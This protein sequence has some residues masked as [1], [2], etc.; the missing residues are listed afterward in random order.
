MS[1][2]R[3]DLQREIALEQ[4]HVDRVY[5]NLAASTASARTL[6]RSGAEIYKTD[7]DD[8]LR[9]ES[10][11]ALFERD[12]FAYQAAKRLAIL[13][14]EHEGLVFGRL[15]LN[16]PETRYIGRLGVRDAEY[17][18]LVIDWRA[19]AAEPFYRATQ[20]TPMNVIRRRVLRCR[21]DNVIGLEDDLLDT[22]VETD[23]PILGEGITKIGRASCRERV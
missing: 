18:P 9:E 7:R 13:D 2:S 16:F 5:E 19:P 17:E 20:A 10:G 6:A 3:G 4:T 11:T 12:A 15:D 21:D 14:A 8:Y 1:T 23:L 22:S